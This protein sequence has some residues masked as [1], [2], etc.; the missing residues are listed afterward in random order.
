MEIVRWKQRGHHA[1]EAR[2]EQIG[3]GER[4]QCT[5]AWTPCCQKQ[6]QAD[7]VGQVEAMYRS[8]DTPLPRPSCDEHHACKGGHMGI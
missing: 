7:G 6:K 8:M 3:Q 4:G 2:N 5:A 1:V